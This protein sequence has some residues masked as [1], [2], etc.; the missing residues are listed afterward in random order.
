MTET[1]PAFIA[2]DWGSTNRRAYLLGEAGQVLRTERDGMGLLSV[3]SDGFAAEVAAIRDRLGNLPVVLAGM[4]GSARGWVNV[5]YVPTP[6]G[7]DDLAANLHWV[8][9]GRTAIVPGLA[10]SA[11]DV[12]RGEEVQFLG[13]VAAGFAS[14]DS[15]LCQPGTH[16]KWARMKDGRIAA[17]STA[18]TGELFGLLRDH[19][20]LADFLK[21][22]VRNGE[23]FREGV[24]A[25]LGGSLT[26]ELFRIRAAAL[27]GNRA[28]EDSAAYASGV[29]IG[30]DVGGAGLEPGVNVHV[31][32]DAHLGALY[33]A[34]IAVAG[35]NAISVDSHDAFVAGIHRIWKVSAA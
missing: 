35:A 5:P 14:P 15:L 11:G 6:A 2:I 3:P 23:A 19:S 30:H 7:I 25:G 32:A 26:T 12:M 33:A 4:V 20:L 27:L 16:C 18:M 10:D 1:K 29:L 24:A 13:A 22:D 34:A 17:F 21:G 8:E 31:L 28:V 9:V